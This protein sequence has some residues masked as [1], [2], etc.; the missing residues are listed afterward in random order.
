M[1]R[2][3][4]QERGY[5]PYL[6]LQWSFVDVVDLR[7][8]RSG[9]L[10]VWLRHIMPGRSFRRWLRWRQRLARQHLR[11]C[12]SVVNKRGDDRGSLHQVAGLNSVVHIHVGVVRTG[13]IIHRILNELEAGK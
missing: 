1:R 4:T 3:T 7:M 12:S 6:P 9:W 10:V 13:L 8:W 2:Q 5:A 11:P